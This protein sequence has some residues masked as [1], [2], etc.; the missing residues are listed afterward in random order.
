MENGMKKCII[1]INTEKK[2]HRINNN[3][4]KT[5]KVVDSLTWVWGENYNSLSIYEMFCEK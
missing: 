5:F 3:L 4:K 2:Q 1:I